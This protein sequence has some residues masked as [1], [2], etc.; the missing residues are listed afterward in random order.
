MAN[1]I[2]K[3]ILLPLILLVSIGNSYGNDWDKKDKKKK[4]E[5]RDS[6]SMDS[7]VLEPLKPLE[8]KEKKPHS[9]HKATIMAMVLPGSAQ[10]YNGQWWKVPILYGGVAGTLYGLTW[11]NHRFKDYRDAFIE[12]NQFLLDRAENPETPYPSK[13]AWD[14]I[15]KPFDVETDP[16]LQTESGQKW[17]LN[18]LKNRKTSFK[19]NRDLCYIIMAGIYALNIID[20]C[21]FAH[22]YDFEID[23][24]LSMHL[25]PSSTYH[26][27]SGGTVGLTLTF[28]F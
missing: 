5:T 9:P 27:I 8:F 18:I 15:K 26:P 25:R 1:K 6:L 24:N 20:A 23:D 10:I 28:N 7:L 17:F 12:Y 13:P 14:K 16:Y 11:N 21:V 22:F 2:L 3:L 4:V 19:R